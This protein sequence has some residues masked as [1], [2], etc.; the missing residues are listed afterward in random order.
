MNTLRV[1]SFGIR[2]FVGESLTPKVLIDFASAFAT[3]VKG[4][5]VLIGRDTRYS[6]PMIH[7][8]VVS[9][10]LSAGCEV[11]DC[12]VCPAP[13]VQFS[14]VPMKAAG[15]LSISGGHNPM[16]WN[17]LSL[18]G[19]DGSFLSP[20]V[21]ETVLDVFHSGDFR[22]QDWQNMGTIRN[23]DDYQEP[24]FDALENHV[25]VDAIRKAGFTVLIDPV[26]GSGCSFLEPFA[27]RFGLSL[28]AMNAQ[29]S[30]YLAREAEP[31]PRSA[32][33]MASIIQRLG[34]HVGFVLS[35]DM[36]RLSLVT[37][38]GDPANEEYTFAVIAN[39]ILDKRT[40][41]IVTNCCTTRMID[42]IARSKNG[43]VVKTPVGQAYIVAGLMDEQGILG[44]EGSGSVALPG[45]SPAFDG[46]LMMALVLEAMV[47]GGGI[48]S[49][50]IKSLPRYSIIKKRVVCDSRKGYHALDVLRNRLENRAGGRVDHT[51]GILV[52][53]DDGWVH[54]R[55]SQTEQMIRVISE[56]IDR[57]VAEQR[58]DEIS[59]VIEQEV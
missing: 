20:A 33:Q 12:G 59:R 18:I 31:R 52:D 54:A 51:D 24:Y 41:T 13:I 15:A 50:L 44:G 46:F 2:G 56:A 7:S 55:A 34:G 53:W 36:G 38:E 14:V 19:S 47:E 40:G 48:L 1:T 28:V 27:R 26:G 32:R 25:N 57:S 39:H 29:P 30:G 10:L 17:A 58:A 9:G 23:A 49:E 35:S 42:D 22:K 3:F 37:E 5:R 4:G 8:A 45:F 16:G 43:T 21:G 11:I 6:S